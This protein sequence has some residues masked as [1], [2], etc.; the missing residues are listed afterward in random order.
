[1]SNKTKFAILT[2]ILLWASAFVGIRA[3]LKSYSPEG[4]AL[5]RFIVAS[6]CMAIMYFRLPK[7]NA[8]RFRDA[9]CLLGI[10][11]LGIGVYNIALNYGE[12]TIPSGVASF[13]VSQSPIVTALIAIPFLGER[14]T[15]PRVLGFIVSFFGVGL[16]S[17]G[18]TDGFK[19]DI[20]ILYVFIATLTGSIF[21][22]C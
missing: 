1:M 15:L 20:G 13:I 6:I 12:L 11:V 7:R 22:S 14:L 16:I 4:M 21:P 3:G 17:L 9:L 2:A 19:W 18:G 5:L 10:G 8:M